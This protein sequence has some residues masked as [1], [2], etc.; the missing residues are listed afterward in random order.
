MET[1]GKY[2]EFYFYIIFY[3][4]KKSL[5]NIF[6][7]GVIAYSNF[8]NLNQQKVARNKKLK[9]QHFRLVDSA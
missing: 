5:K 8:K 4:Y 9:F 6:F 2:D 1:V 3:T 7:V